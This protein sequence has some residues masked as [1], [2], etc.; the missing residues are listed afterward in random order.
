MVQYSLIVLKV[1]LNPNQSIS[2]VVQFW[3]LVH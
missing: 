1:L 3:L 2:C